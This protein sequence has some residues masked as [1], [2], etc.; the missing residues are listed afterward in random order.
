MN[1]RI[2]VKLTSVILLAYLRSRRGRRWIRPRILVMLSLIL[3]PAAAI[4]SRQIAMVVSRFFDPTGQIIQTLFSMPLITLALIMVYGVMFELGREQGPSIHAVNWLPITS[5]EYV[6]SSTL[7]MILYIMP[8]ISAYLGGVLGAAVAVGLAL[9]GVASVILSLVGLLMGG[10]ITEVLKILMA[11]ASTSLY[12]S[13]G[14]AVITIRLVSTT[15][16]IIVFMLITN[17]S[18]LTSILTALT[19][20]MET[21]WMIPLFWPSL[22]VMAAPVNPP[23]SL[24][25]LTLSILSTAALFTLSTALRRRYWFPVEP[26]LKVGGGDYRPGEGLLGRIGLSPREAALVRKDVKVFF[27]RRETASFLAI[28]IIFTLI[29]LMSGEANLVFLIGQPLGGVVLFAMVLAA[30]SVGREREGALHLLTAPITPKEIM[31]AKIASTLILSAPILTLITTVLSIRHGLSPLQAT[32]LILSGFM[33]MVEA[34]VMGVIFAAL[35]PDFTTLPRAR[36]ITQIGVLACMGATFLTVSIT[37]SP[38]LVYVLLHP[39]QLTLQTAT[40]AT[41]AIGLTV[42]TATYIIAS[43]TYRRLPFKEKIPLD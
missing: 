6:A 4:I 41:A 23:E 15:L 31:R 32:L 14:K 29:P 5:S 22:A 26:S 38:I 36:Y 35:F 20:T 37:L 21:L 39:P 13:R 43:R 24:A 9:M 33:A 34:S 25:Y 42:I 8:F 3:F 18:F 16:F 28:P 11:R 19:G 27:R 30:T 2:V 1:P 10:F 17:P 40:T 7:S 12:R